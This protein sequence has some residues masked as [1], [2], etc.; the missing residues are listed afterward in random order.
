MKAR[1]FTAKQKEAIMK[2]ARAG[3][4]AQIKQACARNDAMW[5]ISM[6]NIGL[7]TK[8]INKV[9]AEKEK[10]YTSFGEYRKDGIADFG[11]QKHL[12]D[13][14]INIKLGFDEI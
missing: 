5:A 2:C 13:L 10:V 3:A 7:S 8:T 11:V 6:H 9:I 4:E 12:D 14:G 1:Y